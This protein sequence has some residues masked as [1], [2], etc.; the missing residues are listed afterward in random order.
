MTTCR[1]CHGE[2]L[3]QSANNAPI[4]Y[5]SPDCCRLATNARG[6]N[7]KRNA[8][9]SAIRNAKQNTLSNAARAAKRS[10]DAPERI[11]GNRAA[12]EAEHAAGC[13]KHKRGSRVAV[14]G[15]TIYRGGVEYRGTVVKCWVSRFYGVIVKV[16][17]D[18]GGQSKVAG[19]RV[20]A[21]GDPR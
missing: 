8:K 7:K 1:H 19:Q 14:T 17:R 20:Q 11:S 4:K 15:T 21:I 5:C 6:N 2:I 18:G 13:V 3:R 10:A 16:D 12:T 9:R